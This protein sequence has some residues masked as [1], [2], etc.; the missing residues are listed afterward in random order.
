MAG[1]FVTL[2]LEGIV[3]EGIEHGAQVSLARIGQQDD[4]LL[5]LVLRTLGHLNCSIE[6]CTCRD[7]Y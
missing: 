6:C 2:F 5:A 7:T 1:R 3:L 4:N